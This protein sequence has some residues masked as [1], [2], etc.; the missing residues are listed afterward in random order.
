MPM[1]GEGN[2]S[3]HPAIISTA[4]AFGGFILGIGGATIYLGGTIKQIDFNTHRIEI[5]ENQG[6]PNLQSLRADFQAARV[7]I[8]EL[9]AVLTRNSERSLEA[10]QRQAAISTA[11][12]HLEDQIRVLNDFHVRS[13]QRYAELTAMDSATRGRVDALDAEAGRMREV[14]QFWAKERLE[15]K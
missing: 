3:W 7:V 1:N 12:Q 13:M 14:L 5:L 15:R 8:T 6:S 10:L 9:Q 4:I 2:V 11:I